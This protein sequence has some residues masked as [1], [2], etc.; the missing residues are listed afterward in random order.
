[1]TELSPR[2]LV[3]WKDDELR[4]TEAVARQRGLPFQLPDGTTAEIIDVTIVEEERRPD[5]DIV[6]FR[7]I[8]QLRKPD[9][10]VTTVV[11]QHAIEKQPGPDGRTTFFK[12]GEDEIRGQLRAL[13]DHQPSG[14]VKLKEGM[15]GRTFEMAGA[16]LRVL[17]VEPMPP[18]DGIASVAIPGLTISPIVFRLE[19]VQLRGA[20]AL[21]DDLGVVHHPRVGETIRFKTILESVFTD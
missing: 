15:H 9:G 10:S 3:E 6:P 4:Q 11:Q 12:K 20:P 21:V 1:M 8:I 19:V 18:A 16:T 5:G 14:E 2:E 7:I 17:K 13:V